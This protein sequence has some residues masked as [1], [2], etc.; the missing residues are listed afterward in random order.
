MYFL[1]AAG[2]EQP[3]A[4]QVIESD[5]GEAGSAGPDKESLYPAESDEADADDDSVAEDTRQ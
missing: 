2:E 3:T 1:K 4:P 5:T